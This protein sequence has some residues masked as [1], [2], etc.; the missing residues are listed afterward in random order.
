MRAH[1]IIAFVKPSISICTS[2]STSINILI[3]SI[4]PFLCA[5]IHHLT[6]ATATKSAVDW[7]SRYNKWK[8]V[9]P[10]IFHVGWRENTF[11]APATGS[12]SISWL[13][14]WVEKNDWVVTRLFEFS[15]ILYEYVVLWLGRSIILCV[16]RAVF[17][18]LDK[19]KNTGFDIVIWITFSAFGYFI[20]IFYTRIYF[21]MN[22]CI[23]FLRNFFIYATLP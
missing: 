17:R 16:W 13:N 3:P 22:W 23:R 8:W 10:T 6:R 21:L 2:I 19:Y 5:Y 20:I 1:A 18:S 4:D 14:V 11:G 9:S 15:R 7:C 12:R